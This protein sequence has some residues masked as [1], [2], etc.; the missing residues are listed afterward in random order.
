MDSE[1]E[2]LP[3]SKNRAGEGVVEV[4]AWQRS[5]L[6]SDQ[7]LQDD[8]ELAAELGDGVLGNRD[9]VADAQVKV[10]ARAE[11]KGQRQ[12]FREVDQEPVS[13]AKV[14]EGVFNA[15]LGSDAAMAA[16]QF[17]HGLLALLVVFSMMCEFSSTWQPGAAAHLF[18]FRKASSTT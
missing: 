3:R 12:A 6:G 18:Q 5:G 9:G 11:F 1:S 14:A 16:K 4:M 15:I 2:A 13:G 17:E 7:F 10:A 8:G